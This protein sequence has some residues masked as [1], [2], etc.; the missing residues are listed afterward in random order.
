MPGVAHQRQRTEKPSADQFDDREYKRNAQS[1][2]QCSGTKPVSDRSATGVMIMTAVIMTAE[3]LHGSQ[4][5]GFETFISS[6]AIL[7]RARA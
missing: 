2:Y 5:V 1:G 6:P 4:A 3:I 7:S